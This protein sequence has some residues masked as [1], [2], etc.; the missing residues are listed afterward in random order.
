MTAIESHDFL[1]DVVDAAAPSILAARDQLASAGDAAGLAR[2]LA[3]L[4]TARTRL[5]F[6]ESEVEAALAATMPTAVIAVEGVGVLE[7]RGGRKRTAWDH[8]RL[9]SLLAARTADQR[10]IDPDT[11]EIMARPPGRLAQDVADE[12]LACAGLSYWKTGALKARGLDP[13]D[14][15]EEGAGRATVGIRSNG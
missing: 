11:G 2:V 12:L 7:R 8:P 6:I 13:A 4:R 3:A 9:A 14:F 15:C 10:R 1:L 5:A